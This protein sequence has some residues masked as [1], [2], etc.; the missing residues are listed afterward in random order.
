ME[1]L[2]ALYGRTTYDIGEFQDLVKIVYQNDNLTL[3]RKLYEWSVIDN[4]NMTETRYSIAKKL[5]EVCT[6]ILEYVSL[7]LANIFYQLMS[8]VAGFLEEKSVD[9]TKSVDLPSLFSFMISVLQHPSL[10]VSIPVLH[11]WS[12]LLVSDHIG[13]LAIINSLIAQLLETCAQRLIRYEALPEGS[14]DP[15]IMFLNEDIDTIPERHAFVGNYRRYCS[16]VIE[17]IVQRHAD[18]AIPHILSKIDFALNNI[19][20]GEAGFSRKD[21]SP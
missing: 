16:Q 18:E 8:Y 15:T 13:G 21:I 11:S 10:V 17:I 20:S 7:S 14:D 2:H 5:S 19:Y 6:D 9:F 1:A 3:L 12:R 4:N